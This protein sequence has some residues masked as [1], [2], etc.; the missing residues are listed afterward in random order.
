MYF[1]NNPIKKH[2]NSAN[3]M[4]TK[5]INLNMFYRGSNHA[6]VFLFLCTGHMH[7]IAF[8]IVKSHE[9]KIM[10]F[11]AGSKFYHI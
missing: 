1:A 5:K 6:G 2:H 9:D 7:C 10:G 11:D 4:P 3:I 8:S